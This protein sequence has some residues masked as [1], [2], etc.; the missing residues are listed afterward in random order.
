MLSKL[1]ASDRVVFDFY[2]ADGGAE[3]Y[4][5]SLFFDEG[6][7][8]VVKLGE[9]DD[10]NAHAV[11]AAVGEECFPEDVDAEARV[12]LVEL[13]VER[14]DEDDAPEAIDGALRLALLLQPVEHGDAFGRVQASGAARI[15]AG[16]KDGEH[17]AADGDF[18]GERERREFGERAGHVE[19]RGQKAGFHFA[20]ASLRIEEEQAIE[21]FHFVCGA[22]AAIEIVEIGAAAERDVLAIIDVLAVGQHVGGCAAA[23]ERTLFEK[24]NAP[25][26]FS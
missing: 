26:G 24:T 4:F 19:R 11:A 23:E 8:A 6:A 1:T 25:T 20:F 16:A 21:K 12:G 2:A 14:A 13:F 9:R 18:V 5:P 10:G 3:G 7:A 22:D 15:A 17:G